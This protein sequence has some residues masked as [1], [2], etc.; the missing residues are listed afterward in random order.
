MCEQSRGICIQLIKLHL[1]LLPELE[2]SWSFGL[3][4]KV[5]KFLTMSKIK[6]EFPLY[7]QKFRKVYKRQ[8]EEE[9][10][11]KKTEKKI[12][13]GENEVHHCLWSTV[14]K[15]SLFGVHGFDFKGK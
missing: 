6:P 5:H 8:N 13:L 2:R 11:K 1:T 12:K 14:H 3:C 7:S 10:I 15:V 9:C 4:V